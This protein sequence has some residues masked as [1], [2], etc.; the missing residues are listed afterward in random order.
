MVS[1]DWVVNDPSSDTPSIVDAVYPWFTPVP[2]AN[3]SSWNTN[4]WN[5]VTTGCVVP[6]FHIS[7]NADANQSTWGVDPNHGNTLIAGL[8]GTIQRADVVSTFIEGFDDYWENATIWRA[9]NITETGAAVAYSQTY[10]DYPNQRLNIVRAH[11]NNPFPPN[12]KAEA[13]GAD[14]VSGGISTTHGLYRN[15]N[16]SVQKT[17]DRFGGWNVC[18]T[19]TGQMLR[20]L[21]VPLQGTMRFKVRAA[22]ALAGRKLHFVIDGVTYPAVNMPTTGGWQIWSTIDMGQYS[23]AAQS[24]HDVRLV[25]DTSGVNVNWWQIKTVA[26]PSGNS[27]IVAQQRQ[28]HHRAVRAEGGTGR[29]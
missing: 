12:L 5:G 3:Y 22:T 16:I 8:N 21:D 24:R 9:R 13:E 23:F 20:W 27:K 2:G 28:N 26:L 4:T 10:Y 1:R 6:Q 19:Q 11:S 25:W 29:H 18:S 14:F 15:G 7:S 17:T